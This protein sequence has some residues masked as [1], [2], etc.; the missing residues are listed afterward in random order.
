MSDRELT[1]EQREALEREI[2]RQIRAKASR[3][4]FVRLG[5]MWHLAMYFIIIVGLTVINLT[6]SPNYLWVLWVAGGWGLGVLIHAFATF[7]MGGITDDMIRTE[8]ERE[9]QRRGLV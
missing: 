8:I 4:V 3:K 5:F 1:A 2:E 7:T 9:R 6:H